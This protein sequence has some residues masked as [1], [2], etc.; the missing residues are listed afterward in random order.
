MDMTL[1]ALLN[2]KI[3]GVASGLSKAEVSGTT[4]TLF[5]TNGTQTS[6]DF[7][8]PADGI[9]ITNIEINSNN[10]LICYLSDN[11]T[12][13]AGEIGTV[14]GDDGFSPE[15]S[16]DENNNE[17]TYRLKIVTKDET[18]I[19]PNLKSGGNTDLS[20]YYTKSETEQLISN[21]FVPT[22]ADD[23]NSLLDTIL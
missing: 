9:S 7:P 3:K 1:Y 14:K 8:A 2:K 4:L 20:D 17:N 13:D 23:I 18:I 22:S 12:V 19:T 11:S 15:I 10:H 21:N 6:I 16:E 5:F